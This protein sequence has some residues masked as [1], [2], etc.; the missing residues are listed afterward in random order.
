[1]EGVTSGGVTGCPAI[2]MALTDKR[3]KIEKISYE[4]NKRG[5]GREVRY[6]IG[7]P[8]IDVVGKILE[9]T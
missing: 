9:I 6:G 4:L 5:L 3:E 7:G 8:G 2:L 1:L